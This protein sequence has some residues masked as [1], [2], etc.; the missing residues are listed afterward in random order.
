L[1]WCDRADAL[2]IGT[3][4]ATQ[5]GTL[6]AAQQYRDVG[7]QH[8]D[9]SHHGDEHRRGT[10]QRAGQAAAECAELAKQLHSIGLSHGSDL[11]L[12]MTIELAAQPP[13]PACR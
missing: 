11:Y 10:E 1:D 4:T 8:D 9:V 6:H 5:Y 13:G 12:L 7:A 3:G 2:V